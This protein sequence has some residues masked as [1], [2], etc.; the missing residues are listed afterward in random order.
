MSNKQKKL[1]NSTNEVVEVVEVVEQNATNNEVFSLSEKMQVS[2]AIK[3]VQNNWDFMYQETGDEKHNRKITLIDV[4]NLSSKS[5]DK[6][7]K[8]LEEKI[9]SFG[10]EKYESEI[11]NKKQTLSEEEKELR[12]IAKAKAKE[13]KVQEFNA[14]REE[15]LSQAKSLLSQATAIQFTIEEE[16]S[17]LVNDGT[18]E[19][20]DLQVEKD[21]GVV[22]QLKI[23]TELKSFIE[24]N[25]LLIRKDKDTKEIEIKMRNGNKTS[26]TKNASGN[27]TLAKRIFNG[28]WKQY[29]NYLKAKYNLKIEVN[30]N[31]YWYNNN[32]FVI[33]KGKGFKSVIQNVV[34]TIQEE[35]QKI[36][37]LCNNEFASEKSSKKVLDLLQD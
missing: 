34:S 23:E 27:S 19:K 22:V 9:L 2:K 33:E 12:K 26:G 8:E 10:I 14:K 4:L 11:I 24:S 7:S 29:L 5:K 15:L 36:I 17:R 1:E 30:E 25:K 37:N 13:E 20:I 16:L 31:D 6:L 21:G 3:N 35:K 28:N 18:I 32:I